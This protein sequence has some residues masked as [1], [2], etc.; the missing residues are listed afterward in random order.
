[1]TVGIYT[2]SG[3]LIRILKDNEASGYGYQEAYWDGLDSDG[4]E[5]A[6]G[7]YIYHVIAKSAS[8]EVRSSGKT[9]KMK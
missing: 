7:I 3:R 8:K 2:V 5:A 1:M 6:N 9:V 4:K